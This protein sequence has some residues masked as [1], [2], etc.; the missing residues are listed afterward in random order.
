MTG[1]N[2]VW[3]HRMRRTATPPRSHKCHLDQGVSHIHKAHQSPKECSPEMR[4]SV[5]SVSEAKHTPGGKITHIEGDD[6]CHGCEGREAGSELG[7][8]AGI[9]D[10]LR[11]RHRHRDTDT[12][13]RAHP[14]HCVLERGTEKPTVMKTYMSRPAQTEDTP[15]GRCVDGRLDAPEAV[16]DPHEASGH[17]APAAVSIPS[18]VLHRI[19]K[20]HDGPMRERLV[21]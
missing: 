8:K 5:E 11:L 19:L 9:L 13:S 14:R 4:R 6:V 21:S 15:K 12:I 20:I 3:S 10:L 1:E 18:L 2:R 7:I 16:H 17:E